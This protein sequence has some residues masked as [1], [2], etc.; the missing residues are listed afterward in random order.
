MVFCRGCGKEI[1]ESAKACPHCGAT[2]SLQGQGSK[3]RIAAALLALF[4]GGLGVHKFYLGKIG[5]GFLYII[6]CWTFIPSVIAFVE[7]ILYLFQSD[8]DFARKYG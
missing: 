2:Q 8:E 4:L 6:F 3:N 5:Q 1:H 7:F